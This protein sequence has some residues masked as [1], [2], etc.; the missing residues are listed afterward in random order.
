[1]K[2]EDIILISDPK[3]LQIPIQENNDP[4]VD[5]R[6]YP[7]IKV[8]DIKS[9]SSDSYF[10][11]RQSV[12]NRLLE[13][14]K[15]LPTG[16]NFLITEGHRPLSLQTKYF[17]RYSDKLRKSHPDWDD[18]HIHQEA[19]KYVAPPDIVPPHST[20]GAVDLTLV[21]SN[22]EKLD[23]NGEM[24]LD[25][26]ESSNT[27]FTYSED[28]SEE[29]KANRQILINAMTKAGFVNYPTEWWHWSYGDRYW[30]YITNQQFALFDSI[31]S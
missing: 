2:K 25:P 20:G 23:M 30:A 6:D 8:D 7:Q 10:K 22:G 18:E 13:A 16:I 3:V 26:E 9:K 11:L 17:N 21:G 4:L 27:V 19:S 29:A 24:N 15:Y 1:M 5:I 12:L 28:I 14:K 31:D